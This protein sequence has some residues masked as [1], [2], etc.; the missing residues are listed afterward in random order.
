MTLLALLPVLIGSL[1]LF[2]SSGIRAALPAL[3]SEQGR[4]P[5]DRRRVA[6]ERLRIL[7]LSR[8]VGVLLS[9]AGIIL[10][11][12]MI[13]SVDRWISLSAGG[14]AVFMIA[15]ILP[16]RLGHSRPED[17]ERLLKI[18]FMVVRFLFSLPVMVLL[19]KSRND[20][21]LSGE[22]AFT[23][24]DLMWLE[25]RREKGDQ[26]EFEQ[27]QELMDSILDFSDKIVREIMVPRIDM[28]CVELSD[29]LSSV[30]RHVRRVG[31]SRLPVY[32]EKIDDIAGVLYAKDLITVLAGNSNGFLMKEILREAYFVPEYKRIDEL[33]REFQSHR[34]HMAVVVD[35]Y[36]GTAGLVTL[37]DIVE[38]VFGEI[39]DEYDS[40]A[41]LVQSLGMGAHRVDA[42]LSIDDL[43]DIL[44]TEFQDM[45]YESVGG[46]VYSALGHIPRPGESV[47][48]QGFRFTVDKVRAQRILLIKVTPA[49]KEDREQE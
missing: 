6:I 9:G 41:P 31:H 27:E 21:A 33:F 24:P 43:N 25:Q 39:R 8:F 30:V 11:A 20:E 44:D 46:I 36:G 14:L 13:E 23:P 34:I 28:N 4:D 37:E 47:T 18:P 45:D 2:V 35:E 17:M 22:W 19:G 15:E 49:L 29:D 42:R 26:E 16:A 40:E 32:K 12:S 3:I 38:E 1:L 7:W 5:S 10:A 48:L